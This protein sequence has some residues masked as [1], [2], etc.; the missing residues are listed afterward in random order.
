VML[1]NQGRQLPKWSQV[2]SYFP[3]LTFLAFRPKRL[4]NPCDWTVCWFLFAL[5]GGRLIDW[6]WNNLLLLGVDLH[7]MNSCYICKLILINYSFEDFEYMVSIAA[8][9]QELS[10]TIQV[11][12]VT[13][14]IKRTDS[15]DIQGFM[16]LN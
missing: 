4:E 11:K 9:R 13:I 3:L 2:P 5:H 10:T 7:L 16:L 8:W 12:L 14:E 1:S 6:Q 15:S